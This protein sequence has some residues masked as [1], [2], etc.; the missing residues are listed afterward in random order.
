[1]CVCV[2]VRAC[3]R[4]HDSVNNIDVGQR[5]VHRFK[6]SSCVGPRLVVVNLDTVVVVLQE[7]HGEQEKSVGDPGAPV[8]MG[9]YCVCARENKKKVGSRR[10]SEHY[11][12][13]TSPN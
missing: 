6:R 7:R 11:I 12:R 1:V 4:A 8:P 3:A 13:D 2:C 5:T 9:H 10:E